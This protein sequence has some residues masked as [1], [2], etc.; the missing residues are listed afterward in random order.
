MH[1]YGMFLVLGLATLTGC[2]GVAGP[3]PTA[4]AT[5]TV[6]F[7]GKPLTTGEIWFTAADKG[8]S[9]HAPI[10]ANGKY[11]IKTDLPPADYKVYITPAR[12]TAPPK[13]GEAPPPTPPLGIPDK[14]QV[15]AMSGLTATIKA[16]PNTKD[17]PL[18]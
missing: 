11:D 6:T 13:P 9:A 12:L 4:S 14:Y 5:G 16:G 17:F 15:E 18:E 1:S 3:P 2:G 8:F 10:D 7:G